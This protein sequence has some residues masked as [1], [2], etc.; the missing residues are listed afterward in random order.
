MRSELAALVEDKIIEAFDPRLGT[1][2][3]GKLVNRVEI[4]E[5]AYD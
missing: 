1:G 3:H 5:K 4:L 2:A